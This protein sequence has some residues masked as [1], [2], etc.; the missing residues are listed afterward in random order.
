MIGCDTLDEV[1]PARLERPSVSMARPT[2]QSGTAPMALHT[3]DPLTDRRWEELVAAHPNA[4]VFHQTGWLRALAATYGYKPIVVTD[5]SPTDNL[6]WAIPFCKVESWITGNRLV[7]L[8]F[9]D[10]CTPLLQEDER[11]PG[12]V[13]WLCAECDRQGWRYVE[14]RPLKGTFDRSPLLGSTS[15]WFH[16]LDLT[17]SLQDIFR[18]FDK[19]SIQRRIRRAEREQ[20]AYEKGRSEDLL[21]DLYR[22]LLKTRRRHQS[23]PQ[24]RAWFSNLAESLGESLEV[25]VARKDGTAVAALLTLRFRETVV[26][27]YGCSDERYH[28]LAGIPW[29]FWK[30]IEESKAEGAKLLDFGRTDF[31]HHSLRRFKDQFGTASQQITYFRYP[32]RAAKP[33]NTSN[34]SKLRRVCSFMPDTLL[35][36]AGS[37]AYRHMG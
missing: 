19:D 13:D 17:S 37:L 14:L 22:L 34:L 32:S 21:D 29:L 33:I 20:L 12:F 2:R 28:H 9:A 31:E 16:T 35:S 7:S 30:V 23:L 27:K 6:S 36:A 26:Y 8:P 4:S 10:H 24:P 11:G 18:S 1:M 5:A 25:R 15:Y 3:I